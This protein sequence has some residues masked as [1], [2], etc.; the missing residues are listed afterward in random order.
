MLHP[1]HVMCGRGVRSILLLPLVA[2]CL[3]TID[4]CIWR[5]FVFMS[6]VV[7]VW[8]SVGMFGGLGVLKYVVCL[9]KG[10][11]GC[12]VFCLYCDAWSCRCS[13]MGSMS[14]SSCRCCMFVSCVHP[15]AVL[16]AAFCMTCSLL[17]LVEDARGDHMEEAYS[18]AG[19]MTAL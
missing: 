8:G 9:C 13:C 14:V 7:I 4:V 10:C 6:V 12:C 17:M 15:V 1:T 3:D 19:L 5:M 16:N 2:R 18:R 11:D